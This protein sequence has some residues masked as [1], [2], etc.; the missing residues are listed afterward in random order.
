[1]AA[2]LDSRATGSSVIR[3][4]DVM[5]EMQASHQGAIL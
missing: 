1:M 4:A 3:C 2:C 5:F